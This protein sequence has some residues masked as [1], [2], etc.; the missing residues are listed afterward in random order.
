MTELRRLEPIGRQWPDSEY[1]GMLFVTYAFL[2]LACG[3]LF[4][5]VVT[6]LAR[7][8]ISAAV[9]LL[10]VNLV[11]GFLRSRRALNRLR[12]ALFPS[13]HA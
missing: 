1:F 8:G 4:V 6:V 12:D 3:A 5:A 9:A 7:P 13:H 2:A 11:L 10:G